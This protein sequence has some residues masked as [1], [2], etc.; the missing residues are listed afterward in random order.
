MLLPYKYASLDLIA[1]QPSLN[2]NGV[3]YYLTVA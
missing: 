1:L 2:S 3:K